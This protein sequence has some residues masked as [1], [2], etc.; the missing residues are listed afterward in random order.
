VSIII[1]GASGHGSVI[2]DIIQRTKEH[3]LVGFV[4]SRKPAGTRVLGA[5]VLGDE[6]VLREMCKRHEVTGLC[7]GVGDNWLRGQLAERLADLNLPFTTVVHPSAQLAPSA[8]LGRGVV[9][10]AGAIVNCSA[11]VGDFCIINTKA[12]LDH[13]GQ[14]HANSSLAP[15]ATVGGAVEIGA[16][17]AVGIGAVVREKV[18]IG[19]NTVIGAGAVVLHDIP[20]GVTALGC[21]AR[22]KDRRTVSD[23]YLR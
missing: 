3:R 6:D 4:D 2:A 14:M 20:A 18:R 1:V 12:S 5:P 16:Y 22:V 21:P 17:T 7:L 15:G 11:E 13:D 10:M 9:I 8:R 23:P 19:A